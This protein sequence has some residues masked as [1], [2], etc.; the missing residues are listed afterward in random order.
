MSSSEEIKIVAT[1]NV[2]TYFDKIQELFQKYENDPYMAQRLHFHV[3]SILPSTLENESKNHEKR[4]L[5]NHFL[6]NEQQVFIQVFLSKNQINI[7]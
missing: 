2:Q 5:R 3:T 1:H 4:V 7:F 6:T